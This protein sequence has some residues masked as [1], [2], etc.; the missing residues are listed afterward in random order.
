[1]R[2]RRTAALLGVLALIGLLVGACDDDG[3]ESGAPSGEPSSEAPSEASSGASG[4]CG[5]A[6]P[7][8]TDEVLAHDGLDRSYRLTIPPGSGDEPAP[9][10]LNFHG[11][12]SSSGQQDAMSNLPEAAGARGYVVVSPQGAPLRI[13]AG[14]P[15]AEQAADFEGLAFWNVFGGEQVDFGDRDAS[16]LAAIDPAEIGADDLGF[17]DALLDSLEERLCVDPSRVYATGMS[18][19]GG[20]TAAL[21]CELGDRI[22]AAVPVAGVNLTG[23]CTGSRPVP[24]RAIHGDAD[25]LVLYTGGS[26][27][28]F[29]L[30]NPSVPDRMAQLA[31]VNRCDAEPKAAPQSGGAVTVSRWEGCARGADVELWTVHGGAHVWPTTGAG[32]PAGAIDATDLALAFFDAHAP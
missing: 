12:G 5:D 17:V 1:V 18:N 22:T 4:S 27:A 26:L 3:D 11:F 10:I 15:Q 9:L 7:G 14:A 24:V 29:E 8:T 32:G 13:A 28:G 30:G 6:E 2:I 16:G 19:G 20:M 25:S 31:E 23:V 21:A